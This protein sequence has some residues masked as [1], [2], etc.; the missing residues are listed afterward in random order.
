[1]PRLTLTAALLLAALSYPAQA[2]SPADHEGHHPEQGQAAPAQTSPAG[3]EERQGMMRGGNMMGM[4]MGRGA[5]DRGMAGG[6]AMASPV[7]FRLIFALMDADGDGTITLAEFQSAHER[8]F[9]AMDSNKDGKLTQEEMIAFM[10]GT[11]SEMP[12]H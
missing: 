4:M 6:G 9:R 2:Q 1:M 7:M 8:I 12:Q 10:H 3:P 11:K 5:K